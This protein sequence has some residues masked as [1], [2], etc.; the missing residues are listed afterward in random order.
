MKLS[1]VDM[2]PAS[3]LWSHFF[4][5]SFKENGT[6]RNLTTSTP[7]LD[8]FIMRHASKNFLMKKYA[9]SDSNP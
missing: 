9:S 6:K 5:K 8:N 2:E 7:R 1:H 3:R 4:A